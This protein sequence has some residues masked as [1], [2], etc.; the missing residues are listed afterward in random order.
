MIIQL[1]PNWRLNAAPPG[2][3]VQRRLVREDGQNIG[4]EVWRTI[5]HCGTLNFAIEV[6]AQRLIQFEDGVYDPEALM[7]IIGQLD[8]IKSAADDLA[9]QV[10]E[11][12][13]LTRR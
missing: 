3:M 5:A 6:C 1:N 7:Q 9:H 13:I 2:W 4:D 10:H 11:S 12:N 8:A